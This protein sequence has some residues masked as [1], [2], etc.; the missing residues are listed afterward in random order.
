MLNEQNLCTIR[1]LLE[2]KTIKSRLTLPDESDYKT[3]LQK[4][5]QGTAKK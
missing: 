2:S 5:L 4:G 1:A 3:A